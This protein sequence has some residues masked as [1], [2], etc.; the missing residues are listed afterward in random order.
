MRVFVLFMLV[1]LSST[2]FSQ[3]IIK[4]EERNSRL[5]SDLVE[6]IVMSDKINFDSL[7]LD[8]TNT[9]SLYDA[10]SDNIDSSEL[11][12]SKVEYV[13]KELYEG[14]DE[15]IE[16]V[17]SV[18]STEKKELLSYDTYLSDRHLKMKYANFGL[19]IKVKIGSK[20]FYLI[21]QELVIIKGKIFLLKDNFFLSNEIPSF[22]KNLG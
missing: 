11:N 8:C 17:N 13:I 22:L 16:R 14:W 18:Y 21:L 20:S 12:C 6:N 4:L 3:I 5:V 19:I 1:T 9:L 2:V 10:M 7:K 15:E